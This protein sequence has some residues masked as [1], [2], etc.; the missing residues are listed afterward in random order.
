MFPDILLLGIDHP[1]ALIAEMWFACYESVA[2][3]FIRDSQVAA[4]AF[5]CFDPGDIGGAFGKFLY[6]VVVTEVV[7][8][9]NGARSFNGCLGLINRSF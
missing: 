8:I 5:V 2:V 9:D 7:L 3:D 4:P 6:A 1:G